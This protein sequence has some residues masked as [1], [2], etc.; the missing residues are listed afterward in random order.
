LKRKAFTVFSMLMKCLTN[1]S[2]LR[3]YAIRIDANVFVISG[4]AIKL[5]PNMNERDHLLKELSKLEITKS[6]LKEMD[7]VYDYNF[8]FLELQV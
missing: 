1:K 3:L 2:W 7:L 8:D 4:G 6:F 5:T